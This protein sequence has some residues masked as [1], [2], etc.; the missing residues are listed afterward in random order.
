MQSVKG[1]QG[2]VKKYQALGETKLMRVPISVYDKIK[3]IISRLEN[4][5]RKEGIESV[6]AF[7]HKHIEELEKEL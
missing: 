2:F 4:L 6:Y 3:L 5:G 7:L 1:H